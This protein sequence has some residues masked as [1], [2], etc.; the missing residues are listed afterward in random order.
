MNFICSLLAVVI[1]LVAYPVQSLGYFELTNQNNSL[2]SSSGQPGDW[3]FS[4]I[5]D[6]ITDE[7]S[8]RVCKNSNDRPAK[9]SSMSM[10]C[11][12]YNKTSHK[13]SAYF[14]D[15]GTFHDET[16]Y[17]ILRYGKDKPSKQTLKLDK[18]SF[19]GTGFQLNPHDVIDALKEDKRIAIRIENYQG[20]KGKRQT[21]VF[22]ANKPIF[23]DVAEPLLNEIK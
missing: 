16:T 18:E 17:E 12:E 19:E 15:P 9:D 6:P 10:L 13:L 22:E 8:Y 4:N 14:K 21:Y 20:S 2:I 1:I 3:E 11:I 5:E 7:I 23:M